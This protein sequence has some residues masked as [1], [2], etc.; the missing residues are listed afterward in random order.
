MRVRYFAGEQ[1]AVDIEG[2]DGT[3][4]RFR[5]HEH[6]K[7]GGFL[8]DILIVPWRGKRIGLEGAVVPKAAA[9]GLF[10]L[11]V[12]RDGQRGAPRSELAGR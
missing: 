8:D 5:S 10:G 1:G 9:Q 2:P 3:A 4:I 11:R 7:R 12:V 6:G